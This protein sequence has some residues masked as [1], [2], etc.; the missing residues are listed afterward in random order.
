MRVQII[1]ADELLSNMLRGCCEAQGF[2]VVTERK[3]YD[4]LKQAMDSDERWDL[5]ILDDDLEDLD[6]ES[7]L[8]AIERLSPQ[9]R[10]LLLKGEGQKDLEAR[11]PDHVFVV[12]K[13]VD[14]SALVE[15]LRTFRRSGEGRT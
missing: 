13:P 5:V 15:A 2:T 4:A 1:V 3:G 8:R 9:Q 6:G 10:W 12:E 11:Y 14:F 7:V